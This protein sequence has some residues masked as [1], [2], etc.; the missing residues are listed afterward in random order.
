MT[1]ATT[2]LHTDLHRAGYYPELVADVLDVALA[3]EAV[4]A[5]LGMSG[6]LL[7]RALLFRAVTDALVHPGRAGPGEWAAAARVAVAAVQ[8]AR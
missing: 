3:D 7:L 6:Q 1:G 2:D 5:H 8:R 4:L